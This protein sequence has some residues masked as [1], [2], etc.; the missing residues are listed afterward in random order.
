MIEKQALRLD[1]KVSKEWKNQTSRSVVRMVRGAKSH[2]VNRLRR[3]FRKRGSWSFFT[4]RLVSVAG[5]DM[6]T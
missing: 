2:L 5:A 3:Q 1:D 6:V 4:C